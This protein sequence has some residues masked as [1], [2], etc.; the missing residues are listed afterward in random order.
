MMSFLK[1]V[2]QLWDKYRGDI[3]NNYQLKV[4]KTPTQVIETTDTKRRGGWFHSRKSTMDITSGAIEGKIPIDAVIA[5][6][7]FIEALPPSIIEEAARDLGSEYASQSLTESAHR[8]EWNFF[9]TTLPAEKIFPSVNYTPVR[10][11]RD[12]CNIGGDEQLNKI[13]AEFMANDRY[14]I[15]MSFE[16]Y[17]VFLVKWKQNLTVNLSSKEIKILEFVLGHDMSSLGDLAKHLNLS[18]SWVSERI[19]RLRDKQILY[20]VMKVP[21]SRI[22]IRMFYMY[23]G[24]TS[25]MERFFPVREC[26]FLFSAREILSGPWNAL[27]TLAVP[28]NGKSN[29]AIRNSIKIL[30]DMDVD[31]RLI[32]IESSG[33]VHSFRHYDTQYGCWDIPWTALRGWGSRV[34]RE[35]LTDVFEPVD[36]SVK[37]TELWLDEHDIGLLSLVQKGITTTREQREKLEIGQETL[38]SKRDSLQKEGLIQRFWNVHHVGLNEHLTLCVNRERASAVEIWSRELP[39]TLVRYDANRNLMLEIGLPQNGALELLKCINR[40]EWNSRVE[41]SILNPQVWGQWD[42]PHHLWNVEHQAW[43][44]PVEEIAIWLDGLHIHEFEK[45]VSER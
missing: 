37:R 25:E 28:D 32:E 42:F 1:L 34:V 17:V 33:I 44:S 11:I 7:C 35:G 19:A 27:A 40:L 5:R 41:T 45:P 13:L 39:R 10:R 22:G 2:L 18:K 15:E 21:F 24:E 23:F 4:S 30:S 26:P 43:E 14:G 31:T 9:W 3:E 36:V 38:L 12:I 29:R 6:E 20:Q 16:D 8:K